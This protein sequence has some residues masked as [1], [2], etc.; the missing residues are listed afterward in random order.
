MKKF[1]L[2]L[3][4]LILSVQ[5]FA[6]KTYDLDIAISN[7]TNEISNTLPSGAP[8]AVVKIFSDSKELSAY[9][10]D[11][12]VSQL[13]KKKKLTML[14]RDEKKMSLVDAE[15]D[16]Q[17]S[18][19]VSDDSMV[20]I[21]YKLGAKYLVYGSFDQLGDYMQLSVQAVYVETA[22]IVY[23]NTYS[24]SQSSKLTE[25]LGDE[26]KLITASDFIDTI[27]RCDLKITAIERDKAKEIQKKS[28][29][30]ETE[31]NKDIKDIKS[32]EQEG[33]ESDSE[34]KTRIQ[35]LIDDRTVRYDND[36][37]AIEKSSST[38]YDNQKKMIQIQK[39]KIIED[40]KKTTF[41][42]NGD[43]VQVLVGDFKKNDAPK[44]WP[45]NVKSVDRIVNYTYSGK[46]IAN[47][48]D[49]K[50]EFQMIEDARKNKTIS[51]EI[52]YKLTLDTTLNRYNVYVSTLRVYDLETGKT[53]IN[54]SIDKQVGFADAGAEKKGA[55]TYKPAEKISPAKPAAEE[56]KQSN[57]V[58]TTTIKTEVTINSSSTKT[59]SSKT[60][61]TTDSIKNPF[62]DIN[63]F[64]S[65]CSKNGQVTVSS[66]KIKY[67]GKTYTALT[68]SGSVKS[69]KEDTWLE[70][71]CFD[72]P[73]MKAF[74]KGGETIKFSV[75]GDGNYHSFKI[76]TK[77]G[78]YFS[79]SFKT[80]KDAITEVEI[81]LSK[82]K[83][84]D[85][86]PKGP[87]Y[88][89][90]IEDVFFAALES[91][92]GITSNAKINFSIFN[93]RVY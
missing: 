49:V 78:S 13:A 92:N 76:K 21:G 93:V 55:N 16:F 81:P 24:I 9:I 63:L 35:K 82:M 33:W 74:M 87:L 38:N 10:S 90:N 85:W 75:Q 46:Y 37:K 48:A 41:L 59:T 8:T 51:G 66:S 73:L 12:I 15:V 65:N 61:S 72:K 86:S 80:K 30:I 91:P 3:F 42:L 26:K 6:Q 23:L 77:T 53:L 14:E 1:C 34:Y 18:G 31:Y 68:V 47:D 67:E 28:L 43:S 83:W 79:Y 11:A 89:S 17:Y 36:I 71:A 56:K 64:E 54:E 19:S 62:E 27:S 88:N 39:E 58:P 25:L 5:V 52:T 32:L 20:E 57:S 69:A 50:T 45:V 2:S 29:V 84:Q 7:T 4:L 70:A 40:L 44:N 60:S 22:E